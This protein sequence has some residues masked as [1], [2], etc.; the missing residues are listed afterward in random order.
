[1][2]IKNIIDNENGKKWEIYKES[3]NNYSYKYYEYFKSIGWRLI[4]SESNYSKDVIEWEF[5]IQIA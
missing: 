4:T 5:D 1:M 3:E 2:L